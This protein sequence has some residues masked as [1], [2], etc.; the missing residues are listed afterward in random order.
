[1][2]KN[3]VNL[4]VS[5]KN[6][7]TNNIEKKILKLLLLNKSKYF[8][9]KL[10]KDEIDNIKNIVGNIKSCVIKLIKNIYIRENIILNYSNLKKKIS[11]ILKDYEK[12][13]I[14]DI[15]Q[16]YNN[17]PLTIMRLILQYSFSKDKVKKIFKNPSLLKSNDFKQFNNAIQ[18]DYYT[19]STKK[20][21]DDSIE[22]ELKIEKFLKK[23]NIE[24]KTQDM[25][26]KEQIKEYGFAFNTPDFLITSTLYINN[27]KIN[28]I[29]AKN[30]YGGNSKIIKNNI[31]K[32]IQKY[33]DKYGYGCII[34]GC[35]YNENLYFDN[36]LLLSYDDL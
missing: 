11:H 4:I 29:D 36:V 2:S 16:K 7:I 25:L 28:W 15:S 1:M 9:N 20:Q 32:Q 18:N 6:I 19:L 17:T 12:M 3:I 30:Y 5:H 26:S 21:F 35:G 13:N 31:T 23:N 14:L 27:H 10:T 33:I 22:F 24:Y 34:F 8:Y